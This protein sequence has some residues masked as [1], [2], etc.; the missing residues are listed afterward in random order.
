MMKA[1]VLDY[2]TLSVCVEIIPDDEP[3]EFSLIDLDYRLDSISY[4]CVD[5]DE[6]VPVYF[7]DA[8]KPIAKL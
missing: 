3:A 1:I 7:C 6:P 2:N 8:D 5:D 4:M